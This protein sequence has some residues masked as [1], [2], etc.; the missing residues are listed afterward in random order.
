MASVRGDAFHDYLTTT[1]CPEYHTQGRGLNMDRRGS[2][3]NSRRQD[4]YRR[5]AEIGAY[6]LQTLAVE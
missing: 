5:L 1:I 4:A 6:R 2:V 3:L